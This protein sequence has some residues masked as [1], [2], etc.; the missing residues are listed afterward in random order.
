LPLPTADDRGEQSLGHLLRAGVIASALIVTLGGTIYLWR[1][2]GETPDNRAFHGEPAEYRNP[3]G[4]TRAAFS[5]QGR[6]MIAFGLSVLIATPIVRVV[7][8]AIAFVRQ[9][10]R[11]YL[12]LTIFVL[13]VLL[14][15]LLS[16]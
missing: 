14:S 5:G 1:H 10:D 7:F 3:V 2:G 9:R 13:A 4:I 6:V 16:G 8:S 12:L 15:S 11:L